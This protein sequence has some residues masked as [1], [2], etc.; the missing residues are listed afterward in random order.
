MSH[1]PSRLIGAYLYV[2]RRGQLRGEA[3]V[4]ICEIEADNITDLRS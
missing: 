3:I 2:L 1:A 4:Y